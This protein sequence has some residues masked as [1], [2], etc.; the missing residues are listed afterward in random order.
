MRFTL[1]VSEALV[2]AVVVAAATCADI[3]GNVSP[4]ATVGVYTLIAGY[5]LGR[6]VGSSIES[7]K[8]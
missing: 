5:T 8:R 4:D 3:F 6:T 2:A 7:M 1:T